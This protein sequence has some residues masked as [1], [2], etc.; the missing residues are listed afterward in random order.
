VCDP[1][2]G[3]LGGL[4]D[5]CYYFIHPCFL[6][7]STSTYPILHY[8]HSPPTLIHPS[9]TYSKLA[10]LSYA[11]YQYSP[12][13]CQLF[14]LVLPPSNYPTISPLSSPATIYLFPCPPYINP[15][16]YIHSTIPSSL[17][18][19]ILPFNLLSLLSYYIFS[20][21]LYSNLSKRQQ[22][23]NTDCFFGLLRG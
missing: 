21:F 15:S 2:V 18:F 10:G 13:V 8:T 5:R 11:S 12:P 20:Y 3:G 23:V 19:L 4:Y 1:L 17:Q 7:P 9:S 16:F 6:S 22:N 14:Y